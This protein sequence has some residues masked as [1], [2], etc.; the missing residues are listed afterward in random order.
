[1]QH[2]AFIMD[3]NGRWA[4]ARGLSRLE[5]HR[6]GVKAMQQVVQALL[7][8]GVPYASFYAFSTENWQRPPAEVK[9]LMLLLRDYLTREFNKLIEAGVKLR[10]IGNIA[11]DSPVP[12]EIRELLQAAETRSALNS[13]LTLGLCFNYGGRDEITRALQKLLSQGLK[14]EEVTAE[15]ISAALDTAG[16]PDPDLLIRTSGECRLSNFMSWQT[17]YTELYF[18]PIFWPDFDAQ[19]LDKA[20]ENYNQRDRRFGAAPLS[21]KKRAEG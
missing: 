5:G 14:A 19:A 7:A 13:K 2:I 4:S 8:R 6:A 10:V 21:P 17:A 11:L 16:F 15:K 12:T 18:D 1:M 20:I 9:G 3:G